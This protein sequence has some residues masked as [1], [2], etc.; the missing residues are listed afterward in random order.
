MI[1]QKR[2]K[3]VSMAGAAAQLVFAGV[4]LVIWLWTDS[5]SALSC[6]LFLLAGVPL[7]LMAALL[8]YCRQLER[9]ESE[10][11]AELAAEGAK[12]T[13]IFEQAEDQELRP[14]AA[15]VKFMDRWIVPIFTVGWSGLHVAVGV[16]V[17]LRLAKL[18]QSDPS[19]LENPGQG[20]LLTIVI[21]F[22]AFLLSR[23]ATGMSKRA[24]WRLLRATGSYLLVCVLLM[25]AM[26]VGL[27]AAREETFR[28][29]LVI[30]FAGPIVQII[31]A[32]EL[33][34]NFVLDLYRPRIPGQ[35]H[36]PSFDSRLFNLLAEPEKVGHSIAETLNYQ[37]GFEVSRTWFYQL[38]AKAA[39]PLLVFAILVMF[40]MTS[41]VV[42]RAGEQY[43]VL[44]WGKMSRVL[45]PGLNFKWPW[46]ID[47]ARKFETGSV[48]QLLLGAGKEREPVIVNGKELTLWTEKHGR[49]EELD[50]MVAV[51]PRAVQAIEAGDR[52]PPPSVNLIKLV[53]N[54][55]YLITDPVKFG[56]TYTDSAK[57]LECESYRQMVRYCASATLDTPIPGDEPG[58]PE[59]IMTYG[60]KRA[61]EELKRRIQERAD[62]LDLGVSITYVGL[63][64]VHPP[65]EAA[66]AYEAV[67]QAERGRLITRYEAEAEGDKMLVEVAG[68]PLAALRLALAI[69]GLEELESLRDN[70]D[71]RMQIL[72][73]LIRQASDDIATL[74]KEIEQE[75]LLGQIREGIEQTD[76]QRLLA[77]YLK[78]LEMLKQIEADPTGFD[79]QAAIDAARNK[80]DALFAV[81]V[82][83]PARLVA[84]AD[85]YKA[86]RELTEMA[87]AQ[88]FDKI[89]LAYE[90]SPTMYMTDRWLDVWDKVLPGIAKYVISV[91]GKDLEVRLNWQQQAEALETVTFEKNEQ[92]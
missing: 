54:V 71:G 42:V 47:K 52:R 23:Y 83:E 10:E 13:T 7:W 33:L 86:Q 64:S 50:F 91:D 62:E 87:R 55:Q 49:R 81:T 2:G 92:Q 74:E 28:P 21:G 19:P 18:W 8:F 53:V 43:V 66:D 11:L 90:A 48:Q 22:A 65:A 17:L 14:A 32:A 38:L 27:L 9:K 80:A 36:R 16:L 46:P 60:R 76:R 41:V 34:L 75:R 45:Q 30:A 88:A 31:L 70:P 15:R 77:E 35:E 44:H 4:M 37:F 79:L 1:A 26:L 5:L 82:G 56:Y 78:H 61:A 89:L 58:R 68:T 20:I 51:P 63:T 29:D 72:A 73:D 12:T 24:E 67:L 59:A 57:L 40:C 85:A 69:R 84:E 3:N 25:V 6:L 39:L